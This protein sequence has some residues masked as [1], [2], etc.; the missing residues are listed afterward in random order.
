[1]PKPEAASNHPGVLY[2][3]GPPVQSVDVCVAWFVS[4]IERPAGTL[5]IAPCSPYKSQGIEP[6]S[7][8]SLG[9]GFGIV[10]DPVT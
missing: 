4:I 6:G 9:T 7:L 8:T 5:H 3:A 1:M 2:T 10:P